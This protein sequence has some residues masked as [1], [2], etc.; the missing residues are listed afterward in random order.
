MLVLA[1]RRGTAE[2]RDRAAGGAPLTRI[3]MRL[4]PE[5]EVGHRHS[6]RRIDGRT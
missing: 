2:T 5:L 3:W 6:Y 1:R 4:G